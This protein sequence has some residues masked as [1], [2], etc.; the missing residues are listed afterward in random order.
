MSALGIPVVSTCI[1]ICVFFL[2]SKLL[3]SGFLFHLYMPGQI[4]FS[5]WYAFFLSILFLSTRDVSF[6]VAPFTVSMCSPAYPSPAVRCP[7]ICYCLGPDWLPSLLKLFWTAAK[8]CAH[9]ECQYVHSNGQSEARELPRNS[10]QLEP[11]VFDNK[12]CQ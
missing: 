2:L 11:I 1:C 10:N 4:I 8:L 3:Y 5:L 9:L 12:L 7:F 6:P